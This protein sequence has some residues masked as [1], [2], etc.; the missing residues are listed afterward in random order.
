MVHKALVLAAMVAA[1]VLAGCTSGS[2]GGDSDG[3]ATGTTTGGAGVGGNVTVGNGT[4]GANA[5]MSGSATSTGTGAPAP[6]EASVSIEDDQFVNAT[7]TIAVGGTVTWTHNGSNPHTVTADD[8]SFDSSP[9]CG[10]NPLPFVSDCLE[11]G[12]TFEWTFPEAGAYSYR[13]KVHGG[14]TGTVT[15]VE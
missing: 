2:D 3:E 10:T 8:D 5:T 11:D 4:V 12:D 13:C 14:M 9:N 1:V 7:V 15:V 6:D